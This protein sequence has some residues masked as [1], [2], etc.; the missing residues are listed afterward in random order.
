MSDSPDSGRRDDR[1]ELTRGAGLA[2][3][4][5]AGALIEAASFPLFLWLYGPV[6]FGIYATLQAIVRIATGFTMAGMD[7]ALQRFLPASRDDA[8]RHRVVATAIAASTLVALAGAL[9]MIALAPRL[10]T[11]AGVTPEPGLIA[12]IR[13]YAWTLPLWTAM[14]ILTACIRGLRKFGPEIRIRSV[15][16]PALRILFASLFA[17][18]GMTGSGLVLAHLLSMAGAALM[19]LLL[20]R[21]HFRL[22]ALARAGLDGPLVRAMFNFALPMMPATL[23][24]R[25]FSE[26]PVVLLNV[27][28]PGAAGA[29]AAGYYA[30]ARKISSFLQLLYNSFDYVIAPLAAWREGKAERAAVV[31][32]YAYSTRL[33]IVVGFIASGALLAARGALGQILEGDA[34][35]VLAALVILI[36]GRMGTFVFG[37]APA[38]IRT[39][40]ST[41]WVLANGLVG[42]ALMIVLM[43]LLVEEQGATGAAIAAASGLVLS[44]AL[45]VLEV[46]VFY[47]MT[48]YTRELARPLLVA[49]AAAGLLI[50]AGRSM[51]GW[52]AALQLALL[53][54]G[55]L[56][57]L[58]LLLRHGLSS[59]DAAGFGRLARWLRGRRRRAG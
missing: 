16:E 10:A 21:R 28:V 2:F 54:C 9:A 14:E 7:V 57:A 12:L 35:P 17:L 19:A 8:D 37:Q 27:L 44:A 50:L 26:L 3:L 30:I 11:M 49:L 53:T 46:R 31:D 4:G 59:E 32:M 5:R 1:R 34:A 29:A 41:W 25:F 13:L 40:G 38:M 15:Y 58:A 52:P 22:R 51:A 24:Q 23:I 6:G 48:P 36:L 56:L 20:L 55:L 42:L 47:G 18:V 39:L 43:L 33:M 45:A